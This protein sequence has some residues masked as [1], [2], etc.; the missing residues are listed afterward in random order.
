MLTEI[1]IS[2]FLD[3]VSILEIKCQ[4]IKGDEVR[5]YAENELSILR[6]QFQTVISDLK[7][8]DLYKELYRI[9]LM[10]WGAMDCVFE[11]RAIKSDEYFNSVEFTIDMNIKR[12]EI[13][14]KIDVTAGSNI[15]E[16]KSYF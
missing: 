7:I 13:K 12:S 9:N 4:K 15:R 3:K 6:P 10:I 14:R 16:A 1:S 8:Y 11:L 5:S 2:E